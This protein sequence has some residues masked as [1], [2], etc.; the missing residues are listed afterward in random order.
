MVW[1]TQ[2]ISICLELGWTLILIYQA[3]GN[4]QWSCPQKPF[5]CLMGAPW[6]IFST[7]KCLFQLCPLA[8]CLHLFFSSWKRWVPTEGG[9]LPAALEGRWELNREL[10]FSAA[11]EN[12]C[13]SRP[14]ELPVEKLLQQILRYLWN[15]C[16]FCPPCGQGAIKQS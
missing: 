11:E 8:G 10:G 2:G 3:R 6:T 14:D 12:M 7:W 13:P 9:N 15:R 5:F 4:L 16:V 1:V